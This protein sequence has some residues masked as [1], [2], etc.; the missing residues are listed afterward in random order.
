M[1]VVINI[2]HEHFEYEINKNNNLKKENSEENLKILKCNFDS[3]IDY[4]Y[5]KIKEDLGIDNSIFRINKVDSN[6]DE[7]LS[8]ILNEDEI[9]Y[10]DLEWNNSIISK[11]D[12]NNKIYKIPTEVLK[13][14]KLFSINST[15]DEII[16][17]KN[18]CLLKEFLIN[19]WIRLSLKLKKYIRENNFEKLSIPTPILE[20][21]YFGC[22]DDVLSNYVGKE[23]NDF[24]IRQ[25]IDKLKDLA[26]AFEYLQVDDLLE[27]VCAS[28]A[29]RFIYGK[30][31]KDI[32][33]LGII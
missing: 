15:V 3:N 4:L 9:C 1:K 8:K 27:I 26:E 24:L 20:G 7:N 10:L 30:D 16:F 13:D 17:F 12:I 25:S 19:D 21:C 11:V 31:I 28:I 29:V 2:N 14:S 32:K 18:K 23:V 22:K 5:L 6:N 33:K